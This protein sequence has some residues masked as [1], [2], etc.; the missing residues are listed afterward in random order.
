MAG[1]K[2]LYLTPGPFPRREGELDDEDLKRE[3]RRIKL[4]GDRK[5]CVIELPR[6]EPGR[7]PSG[8]EAAGETG[9]RTRNSP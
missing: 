2:G 8:T 4:T 9:G 6:S 1:R 3:T 5:R 7:S